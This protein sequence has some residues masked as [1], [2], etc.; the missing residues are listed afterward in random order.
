MLFSY[1]HLHY[2]EIALVFHA[3]LLSISN[4]FT[5]WLGVVVNMSKPCQIHRSSTEVQ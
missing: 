5:D 3:G 2:S 4:T 1:F